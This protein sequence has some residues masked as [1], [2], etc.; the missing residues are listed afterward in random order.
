[1]ARIGV[2]DAARRPGAEPA[3]ARGRRRRGVLLAATI[4]A[5]LAIVPAAAEGQTRRNPPPDTLPDMTV[6]AYEPRSTLVVSGAEV[7]RAK[8]PFVDVHLH[9]D[10]TMDP[11]QLERMVADMD[12]LNLAVGVNLS[13]GTGDRLAS[14]VQAFEASH[15]G[16]F[17]VFANV[18][19]SDIDNPEFGVLAARRLEA[20][21]ASGAVGLKIFKNLGMSVTDA[22]GERVRVDDPRLDPIWAKAGELG[23]PVLIHTADPSEF[24]APMDEQNERWLELKLRPGRKQEE[25]PTW[26]QLIAE[27]LQMFRNHPETTFIAAHL[28]WMGNDLDRLGRTLDEIPNMNVGLGAVIYD[29]GRQPRT[30]RQFFIDYQDRIFMGKDSWA[31]DEY[32]TYFR[33]LESDDEY[34][35]Y[36]R[37]YHAFWRMYGLDLP[38]EVLRKVYFEN[39]LRVIPGIDRS[40]FQG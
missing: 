6:E 30:G 28:A 21:H 12:R 39:A 23:M 17:V 40:R 29:P 34:F 13:G 24:W 37:K 15:P 32:P 14:Q 9:I 35:P 7:P 25:P 3:P 11:A 38:D 5:G 27:Q 26:E 2:V 33:V 1:M 19:F 22:A 4:L 16:R 10:A 18:D 36:Y 31:P 8:Y 20:D